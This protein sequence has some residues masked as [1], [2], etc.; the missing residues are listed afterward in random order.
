MVYNAFFNQSFLC[1][2]ICYINKDLLHTLKNILKHF[3]DIGKLS[4]SAL[5]RRQTSEIWSVFF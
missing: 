5:N 2:L 3:F 4:S 1:T